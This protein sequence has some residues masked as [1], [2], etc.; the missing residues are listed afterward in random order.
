MK[1]GIIIGP[2]NE[3]IA[4]QLSEIQRFIQ[5]LSLKSSLDLS[6]INFTYPSFTVALASQ[7][8]LLSEPQLE[9]QIENWPH[10]DYL[11]VIG[12]P[13]GISNL[14]GDQLRQC[15]NGFQTKR[16]LPL[17]RLNSSNS[18]H[19]TYLNEALQQLVCREV[20]S[21]ALSNAVQYLLG[22]AI[23]NCSQHSGVSESWIQAQCYPTKGFLEIGIAD[24]GIGIRKSYLNAGFEVEN[25]LEAFKKA[26][27]GHSV[28]L[29]EEGRGYGIRTS[30]HMIHSGLNGQYVLWSGNCLGSFDTKLQKEKLVELPIEASFRGTF[31]SIRIPTGVPDNFNY[32]DYVC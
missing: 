19:F 16:Y 32:L 1:K 12:F 21:S 17:I 31:V 18:A 28:K 11:T 25:D 23:A 26:F 15:L 10:L 27:S 6:Q 29:K 5:A 9:S 13:K 14:N 4:S 3:S 22:E 20:A 30:Q 2:L 24:T 8:S 7:I